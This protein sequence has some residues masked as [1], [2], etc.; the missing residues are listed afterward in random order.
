MNGMEWGEGEEE[1]THCLREEHPRVSALPV[2][3]RYRAF[4]PPASRAGVRVGR[5][6]HDF[7][8]YR[9]RRLDAAIDAEMTAY[10]TSVVQPLQ[11]ALTDSFAIAQRQ[12]ATYQWLGQRHTADEILHRFAV[13]RKLNAPPCLAAVN[14]SLSA[15]AREGGADAVLDILEDVLLDTAVIPLSTLLGAIKALPSH[16]VQAA[17]VALTFH[18]S[19]GPQTV[20]ASVWG[21]LGAALAQASLQMPKPLEDHFMELFERILAMASASTG[22]LT[23][24]LVVAYG[25]CLLSSSK[26]CSAAMHL[27]R[28]ELLSGRSRDG[29]TSAPLQLSGFLSD[30]LVELCRADEKLRTYRHRGSD[31]DTLTFACD[32]IKYAFAVR[33]QLTPKVFDEVLA[34]CDQRKE[35]YRMCIL[36]L[37]MC[38][39]STPSLMSLLRVLE[40][41]AQIQDLRAPLERLLPV[42][43]TDFFLWCLQ[44]YP[45]LYQPPMDSQ[46]HQNATRQVCALLGSLTVEESNVAKLPT[47]LQFLV[48]DEGIPSLM[49]SSAVSA[50]VRRLRELRCPAGEAVYATLHAQH[51]ALLGAV[52]ELPTRPIRAMRS[53]HAVSVT[54]ELQRLLPS[55]SVYCT[56]LSAAALETLASRPAAEEAF[57]RMMESYQRKCGAVALLPFESVCASFGLPDGALSMLR[58]W[59][60]EYSWLAVLSLGLSLQLDGANGCEVCCAAFAATRQVHKK[61]MFICGSEAEAATAKEKKVEPVIG[62]EALVRRLSG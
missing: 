19:V 27:V 54:A 17:R 32:V 9:R 39:L 45:G 1:L 22:R 51:E 5:S 36:F 37:S 60:R 10:G 34:L 62:M 4:S 44:R 30:L 7:Y 47:L 57:V 48:E 14:R 8:L 3:I 58:R 35:Y 55:E 61:V 16:P 28:E 25:R 23:E 29:F 33:V 15:L 31:T 46:I 53:T 56:V 11:C 50:A 40:A 41:V 6:V 21:N 52:L 12:Q 42:S 43:C 18:G 2:S 13:D 49:A 24:S 20:P 59:H 38:V 26:P